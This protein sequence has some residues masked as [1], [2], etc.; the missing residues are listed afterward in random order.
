MVS[1]SLLVCYTL[2]LSSKWLLPL[3]GWGWIHVY[4]CNAMAIYFSIAFC[5]WV[6]F[7][8]WQANAIY[9]EWIIHVCL[10]L[11][12]DGFF[13]QFCALRYLYSTDLGA[14]NS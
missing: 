3:I 12:D 1:H 9:M 14:N 8:N 2:Q 5:K 11:T 13:L 10:S 4:T 6:N 7:N